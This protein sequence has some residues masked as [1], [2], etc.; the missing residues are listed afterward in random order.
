MFLTYQDIMV[1]IVSFIV[2]SLGI[3]VLILLIVALVK[4]INTVC[5]V[6]KLLDDNAEDICKTVKK[7]PELTESIDKTLISVNGTINEVNGVFLA[8]S[9]AVN[10]VTRIADIVENIANVIISLLAKRN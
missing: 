3:A 10:S 1:L 8:P 6:N 9:T 4:L 7:L 5:K 2:T